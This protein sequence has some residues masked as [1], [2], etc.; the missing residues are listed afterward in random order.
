MIQSTGSVGWPSRRR[1][2]AL[3]LFCVLP[4]L[5]A[6][7]FFLFAPPLPESLTLART[8]LRLA[9]WL[10]V[11]W[12]MAAHDASQVEA[13]AD[14][15]TALGVDDVYVFIS[16]LKADGSFNRTFDFASEF[17]AAL[18]GYAPEL[19]ALAWIGV[20][21]S[22]PN[23][24]PASRLH[25]AQIRR[26]I[27]DFARF[28]VADLGFDGVHINAELIADG[29]QA[30]LELLAAIREAL[31]AGAFLSATAHPLRLDEMVTIMPYPAV[32]HHWSAP[33]FRR[34]AQHV[35]QIVLMAY[36]SGLVFPRDYL[37]WARF[38]A[39]RSQ[40]ALGGISA[41]LIIGASVSEEWTISHQ[42]QAE[43]LSL[44]I[45]GLEAGLTGRL[46]GIALYP[47]WEL[48]KREAQLIARARDR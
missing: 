43:S 18:K 42:T 29:D 23:A 26:T 47:Y 41:E 27:A 36:D 34:V 19:R 45:A 10:S 30:F 21:V 3:S 48:D 7:M 14:E 9:T 39:A 24:M 12:S 13:L 11:S 16:Y 32:A 33:Y 40:Q 44:F 22:L 2:A 25:S 37:N 1:L 31:P 5:L 8:D 46:D 35:D 20:P 15:L 6:L 4:L 28:A 38:Q 17:V